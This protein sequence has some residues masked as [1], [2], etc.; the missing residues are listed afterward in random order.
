LFHEQE[1]PV[2]DPSSSAVS[3]KENSTWLTKVIFFLCAITTLVLVLFLFGAF[4]TDP[5][6]KTTLGLDGSKSNGEKL[7]RVNCVGCHGITAQG[8]LGPDLHD[9]S[10]HLSDK[11]IINQVIQGRTP[12]MPSFQMEPQKMA[13]LLSYLKS[14]N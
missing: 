8:L 1:V 9:V 6:I 13:D 7:F 4:K 2:T 3:Q 12:P 11:Q 10:Y 5:Y 14:L